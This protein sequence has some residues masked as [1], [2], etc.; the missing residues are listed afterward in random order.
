MKKTRTEVV[1]ALI[2]DMD[3]WDTATLSGYAIEARKDELT[4]ASL[5]QLESEVEA[6]DLF[7]D[8]E[9]EFV[10]DPPEF[11]MLDK[12]LAKPDSPFWDTEAPLSTRTRQMI[13]VRDQIQREWEIHCGNDGYGDVDTGVLLGVLNLLNTQ[14][15]FAKKGLDHAIR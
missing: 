7:R 1:N 9:V 10:E 12:L 5:K 8:E 2:A 6:A 3:T 13:E 11:P 14:I 4:N 15:E